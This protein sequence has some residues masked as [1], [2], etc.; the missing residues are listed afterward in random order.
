MPFTAAR[1][2]FERQPGSQLHLAPGVSTEQ[3]A[4]QAIARDVAE[5]E[6]NIQHAEEYLVSRT[7]QG[8]FSYQTADQENI[9]ITIP[10]STA[11]SYQLATYWDD[12][13][14]ANTRPLA[15]IFGVKKILSNIPGLEGLAVT[16]AI[17]GTDA[18]NALLEL[19]EVGAVKMLGLDGTNVRAGDITFVEQFQ[20][21]GAIFLGTLGGVRFWHYGRQL[22]LANGTTVDLIRPKWVEFINNN[23]TLSDR[24]M[25]YGAIADMDALGQGV[26]ATKRFSKQWTQPDPSARFVLSASRPCPW[27]RRANATVSVQVVAP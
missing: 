21:T 7:L 20:N 6:R 11:N 23:A 24:V 12:A 8:S 9:T 26:M 14:P 10:R 19:V 4:N 16:D 1:Y 25:Y 18:A 22:T 13:T 17:C 5:L 3:W 15:D 27:P 2:A